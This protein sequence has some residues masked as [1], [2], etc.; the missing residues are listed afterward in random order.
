MQVGHGEA[1]GR[2]RKGGPLGTQ[3]GLNWGPLTAPRLVSLY[4]KPQSFLGQ[5]EAQLLSL[6]PHGPAESVRQPDDASGRGGCWEPPGP[7]G[8]D[9]GLQG[10]RGP[11]WPGPHS[12]CA[13]PPAPGCSLSWPSTHLPQGLGPSDV[14]PPK[15]TSGTARA[16]PHYCRGLPAVSPALSFTAHVSPACPPSR[17][18]SPIRTQVPLGLEQSCAHCQHPKRLWGINAP[19]PHVPPV[20]ASLTIIRLNAAYKKKKKRNPVQ[21]LL[22]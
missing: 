6:Q 11:P 18:V 12:P 16:D 3:S 20:I 5:Q 15:V 10:P 1:G 2:P 4:L 9:N 7:L 17:A 22:W 14:L 8:S 19:Y 21:F 13:R